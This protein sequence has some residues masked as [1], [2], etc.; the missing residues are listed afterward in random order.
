MSK[1]EK[2]KLR[3]KIS[4][5]VQEFKQI[6]GCVICGA[7]ENLTFHH[8]KPKTKRGT[9][10][11]MISHFVAPHRI[12]NEILKCTV[13]CEECHKKVHAYRKEKNTKMKGVSDE[14]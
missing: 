6:I 12:L 14:N 9:I 4:D 3:K 2:L 11:K 8:T 13:L 1:Q 10:S 7:K 5:A